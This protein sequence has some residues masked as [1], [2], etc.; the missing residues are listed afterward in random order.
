MQSV[1]ICRSFSGYEINHWIEAHIHAYS[2]FGGVTRSLVSDN[3][4]TVLLR[5][6]WTELVLNRSY[7][8]M[9]EQYR[10]AIIPVRLARPRDK[11]N[12]EGTVRLIETWILATLCNRKFFTF[13]E[14]NKAIREKLEEFNA[15]PFQKRKEAG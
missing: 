13:D 15:K 11:P 10:T 4:K 7:H 5:E 6:S 12:T 14:L 2:F 1:R 3:V 9:A 8:E